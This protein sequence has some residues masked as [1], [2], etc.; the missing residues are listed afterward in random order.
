MLLKKKII[1]LD[2][3]WYCIDWYRVAVFFYK[4]NCDILKINK[5]NNFAK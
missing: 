1:N 3:Y 5:N 4:A 2:T